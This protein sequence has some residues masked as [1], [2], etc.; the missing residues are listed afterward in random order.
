VCFFET[1][2]MKFIW[3]LFIVTLLIIIVLYNQIK[4]VVDRWDKRNYGLSITNMNSKYV[5]SWLDASKQKLPY[6]GAA[7]IRMKFHDTYDA[8]GKEIEEAIFMGGTKGKDDALLVYREGRLID[9]IGMTNLSDTNA[10]YAIVSVDLNKDG[11]DD[12]I[13]AR[14]NGVKAYLQLGGNK[15]AIKELLPESSTSTPISLVVSDLDNDGESDVYVSNF[16]HP[17][18]FMTSTTKSGLT[19]GDF[20]ATFVDMNGDKLP[21][22]VLANGTTSMEVYRNNNGKFER[23][24]RDFSA[25]DL[26]ADGDLDIFTQ[27]LAKETHTNHMILRNN[28]DHE[29][30]RINEGFVKRLKHVD[31]IRRMNK[32]EGYIPTGAVGTLK[33]TSVTNQNAS[34]CMRGLSEDPFLGGQ[35]K[36]TGMNGSNFINDTYRVNNEL[37]AIFPHLLQRTPEISR[38]AIELNYR[39]KQDSGVISDEPRNDENKTG[40]SYEKPI[41]LTK[42]DE[43]SDIIFLNV[44][45]RPIAYMSEGSLTEPEIRAYLASRQG[46]TEYKHAFNEFLNVSLPTGVDFLNAIIRVRYTQKNHD[47]PMMQEIPSMAGGNGSS[48][49]FVYHI[50][51][52]GD[53]GTVIQ[54]VEIQKT[55]GSIIRYEGAKVNTTLVVSR[56]HK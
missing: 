18:T 25:M 10:T 19:N 21:D 26:D 12:L 27:N 2:R 22:L 56:N 17:S 15:F 55:D 50:N 43:D 40:L 29:I 41:L 1:Y 53:K 7:I 3:G 24:G 54:L 16:T 51:F 8:T 35:S 11:L 6:V 44:Y 34:L 36:S 33:A 42:L 14:S 28:G 38:N 20:T 46:K 37:S 39:T 47:E 32:K 45:H 9:R 30:V 49:S 23:A 4:L 13:I 48:S 5:P 31:K 52:G